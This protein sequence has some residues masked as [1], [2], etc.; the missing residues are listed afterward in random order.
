MNI[1]VGDCYE[2]RID[3]LIYGGE[4]IGRIGER[5]VFVPACAL[6]DLLRVRI[7]SVERRH[8]RAEIVSLIEP[9]P[10]RRTPP[11]PH[12][13]VCGGCQ[14]QHLNYQ[15]QLTAKVGFI[16][17]TLRR[18]GHIDYQAEI[19]I[20]HGAEFN[21]RSR[22]QFKIDR[23]M[24]PPLVGFYRS[25][26]HEVCDIDYCMVL[27]SELNRALQLV[28]ASEK[29][30]L[31]APYTKI[32]VAAGEDSRVI[33]TQL[34][35]LSGD[36]VERSI[37]GI[38]YRYSADCF[39]Q[40]NSGMLET[41]IDTALLDRSGDTAIDLYAGV[42]LFS[43]QLARRFR[44]VMATEVGLKAFRWAV[45]N[46]RLNGFEN[47]EYSQL[48]AER[49]LERLLPSTKKR[50]LP[51]RIDSPDL[52]LLDP[53]RVGASPKVIESILR[54]WPKVLV[55]VSCDPAT[56]ARDLKALLQ[57][58]YRLESI[59]GVDLFPQS[60]HIETVSILKAEVI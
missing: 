57:G 8:L 1:N 31:A 41:L 2:I 7:T 18:I 19:P 49:F 59:T 45:E 37:Y 38:R 36:Y 5:V 28:R 26:T 21:Y 33:G 53:P 50:R 39:F 44:R 17:D 47:I 22:A 32:E 46:I 52:L 43:L 15:A 27:N 42:G 6:G 20:L 55:Y 35:C 51:A 30:I 60:Y 16:R 48:S 56:L 29:E 3:R 10:Q 11:C 12:F 13:G 25:A 34:R 4:G 23:A 54:L 24:R 9:S 40:V 58:G 14:L